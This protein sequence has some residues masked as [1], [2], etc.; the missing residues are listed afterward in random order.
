MAVRMRPKR[1]R[2]QG[3]A[4][5]L[6]GVVMRHRDLAQNHVA[7]AGD[8]VGGQCRVQR[9][10]GE[11]VDRDGDML[12]GQVDVVDRAVESRVGVDVAAMRLDRR[13]DLATGASLRA[14]EQHVFEKV[15]KARAEVRVFMQAAGLHPY[16]HRGERGRTV[17][18]H[19]QREAV[20]ELLA[21]DRLGPERGEQTKI[22]RN[23][24]G[25]G[26]KIGLLKSRQSRS[27][28]RE[29]SGPSQALSDGG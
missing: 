9:S 24:S 26:R 1:R 19:D 29:I 23:G 25:H 16:L 12:R 2:K 4:E 15:R 17:R 6:I 3:F 21:R 13:T 14:L 28:G 27:G 5:T 18:L 7:L 22:G 20:R 8:L 10:V 11:Q